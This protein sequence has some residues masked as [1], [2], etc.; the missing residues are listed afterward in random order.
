M[1]QRLEGLAAW[2]KGAM[3]NQD[4]TITAEDFV[5]VSDDASFRRY[6]RCSKIAKPMIFMDAPPALSLIH[7]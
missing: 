3:L 6:F 1:D 5:P 2:A 7:I 4:Q